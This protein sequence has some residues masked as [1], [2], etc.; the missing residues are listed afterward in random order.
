M[1]QTKKTEIDFNKWQTQTDYA[2]ENGLLLTTVSQWVRRAKLG[3]GE[4]KIEYMDV[5]EL[6]ITLVK[7]N[8]S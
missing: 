6:G 1:A 3:E 7:K 5:P 4:Q 2:R 8:G